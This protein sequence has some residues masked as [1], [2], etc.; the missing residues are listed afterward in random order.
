MPFDPTSDPSTVGLW[1]DG[2]PFALNADGSGGTPAN[3]AQCKYWGDASPS[4]NPAIAQLSDVG[5]G[6]HA[7]TGPTFK[8]NQLGGKPA[9]NFTGGS[10]AQGLAFGQPA[11]LQ[12]LFAGTNW[13]VTLVWRQ[14]VSGSTGSLFAKGSGAQRVHVATSFNGAYSNYTSLL[15]GLHT[16]GVLHVLTQTYDQVNGN[17][18]GYLDGACHRAYLVTGGAPLS[19]L[20][21]TRDW[22]FGSQVAAGNGSVSTF[23]GAA[24]DVFAL[25]LSNRTLSPAECK[26][27][28]DFWFSRYAV[29][30]PDA[31]TRFYVL[32]DS[33]SL[34]SLN[35][36][37]AMFSCERV[38]Y[39]LGIPQ[40]ALLNVGWGGKTTEN[41]I[42][43]G[44]YDFIPL[45]D[46][47]VATG[48]PV[49]AFIWELTNDY[50]TVAGVDRCVGNVVQ[51]CITSRIHC[52]K[53]VVGNLL[54]RGTITDAIRGNVN[55]QL[56]SKLAASSWADSLWDVNSVAI[57]TDG[58][59]AN[60]MYYNTDKIHYT[61]PAAGD[62]VGPSVAAAL[63]G[64]IPTQPAATAWSLNQP[65]P[66]LTNF[67]P[68][69]TTPLWYL[70][71]N[72]KVTDNVTI[73][74][75][76]ASDVITPSVLAWSNEFLGKTF[77]IRFS[78]STSA[79]TITATPGSIGVAVT[80]A[81]TPGSTTATALQQ[82]GPSGVQ[83]TAPGVPLPSVKISPSNGR[84][85]GPVN[86][87]ITAVNGSISP[88]GPFALTNANS[89]ASYVP[90]P[91]GGSM[92]M[93]MTNDG[94]LT[95]APVLSVTAATATQ[96]LTL[97]ASAASGPCNLPSK[98]IL[99]AATGLTGSVTV[100]PA[101][102]LGGTFSPASVILTPQRPNA[103]VRL[104]APN[105]TGVHTISVTN[106]GGLG[107][108]ANVTW[109]A[110]AAL[111]SRGRPSNW[112]S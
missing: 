83:V 106:T 103:Q 32:L 24:G 91:S 107:N 22:C 11:A 88:P 55:N 75:S 94:S 39:L 108:P 47:L 99:I 27:M 96:A 34:M 19:P 57:G 35:L 42:T 48:K 112:R 100:T 76:D 33:N 70:A 38:A 104:L 78:A 61:E 9:L 12:S 56:A 79:R 10:T 86:V 40:A 65:L 16:F 67:F 97:T 90:T 77:T 18:R 102:S 28:S 54:P 82:V 59:Y 58:Q 85:A 110:T 26:Q 92:T 64:V 43:R 46:L 60:T 87:T 23:T 37:P 45:A 73:T 2:S 20:D 29:T 49:Y 44:D 41:M 68:G 71:P 74:S 17:H 5:S 63:A 14:A 52:N 50:T 109:T 1:Y 31:G 95:N 98:S 80:Q 15:A 36:S 25:V 53:I 89:E 84:I 51:K 105:A 4:G 69:Q 66:P 111:G 21:A 8:T 6:V 62:L 13:S 3:N 30:A 101:D 72:G 81:I 93:T 7:I